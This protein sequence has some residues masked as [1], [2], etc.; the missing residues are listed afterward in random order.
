MVGMYL[1]NILVSVRLC[2]ILLFAATAFSLPLVIQAQEC[3]PNLDL[4]QGTFANWSLYTG[5]VSGAG[6]SNTISLSPAGNFTGD[7]H[8]IFNRAQHAN[9]RDQ[10][11]GF[12]VVCPNGSGYSMKLG[13]NSGGGLAEGISYEFT[14]PAGRNNYSITYHYAVVFEGPNHQQHEQPRLELEVVN[15]TDNKRIEC[16]SFT[17][18]PFGSAL[19]GFYESPIRQSG[20]TPVWCKDWTAVTVNL[21]NMAGKTI[22]LF[23]KTADC[24]FVRHFGY[25]YIDVNTECNNEFTGASYCKFDTAVNVV[26]PYG[27]EGYRWFTSD[28][29]QLLGTRQELRLAPPPAPGTLL[30]LEVTPYDGYGCKDTLYARMVDTLRITARAGPDQLYCG[31]EAVLLGENPKPGL[32]YRWS[33]A[34]GLSDPTIA[35]PFARPGI[36]T[37]YVVTVSSGGGGCRE[38][39]TVTI[40]AAVPDTSLRIEG[41]LS[42]CVTTG[43]S[44]VLLT[45]DTLSVQWYREGIPIPGAVQPRLRPLIAGN[46]YATVANA[47]GCRLSTRT[48]QVNIEQPVPGQRYPVQYAFVNVPRTLQARSFA[49]EVLWRPATHLDNPGLL[50]PRFLNRFEAD[51]DYTIQL[52]TTAG[53]VTIDTQL[54]KTIR[55]VQVFVPD[56]FTPNGDGLNDLLFPTSV[57]MKEVHQFRV[58]NRWG[59]EMYSWS[60]G[61]AGWNGTYRSLAQEPGNYVWTFSGK[62]VDDKIYFRKGTVVLIR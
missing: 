46:Y 45:S 54:V 43:D 21:A 25:A 42:Y 55:E 22:R 30:A 1:R 5:T 41:R 34:T 52:I 2:G 60:P 47:L 29:S 23:F 48:V 38:T 16:S 27:F 6:G 33:P 62:G 36:T 19:P 24:V 17:F 8:E 37:T 44:T 10:F 31:T 50:Q 49:A 13:N 7:R 4:E 35:N 3:P 28:F 56:A 51:Q 20:N 32:N 61:Q 14:I 57:G 26:A 40:T 39:D 18:I 9:T 58:F 12:P 11:G 53:C 15:V 59:V